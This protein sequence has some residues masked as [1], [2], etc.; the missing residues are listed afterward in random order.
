M[1]G[2]MF[3]RLDLCQAEQMPGLVCARLDLVLSPGWTFMLDLVL[4]PGWTVM[5][6]LVLS[7]G[8]T[9][10]LELLLS[11]GW[12]CCCFLAAAVLSGGHST[13]ACVAES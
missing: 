4:S 13:V 9:V 7:P 11:P 12:L 8:W 2:W 5:L 10:M 1:L 3:A 6:D